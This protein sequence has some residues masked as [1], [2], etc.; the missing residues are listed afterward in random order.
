MLRNPMGEPNGKVSTFS[1]ALPVA[2][3]DV[4]ADSTTRPNGTGLPQGLTLLMAIA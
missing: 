4:I 3:P 2:R 1:F